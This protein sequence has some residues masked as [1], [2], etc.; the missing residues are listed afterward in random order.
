MCQCNIALSLLSLSSQCFQFTQTLYIKCHQFIHQSLLFILSNVFTYLG[1][2]KC[3]HLSTYLS[4]EW[5][6]TSYCDCICVYSCVPEWSECSTLK[7]WIKWL[8]PPL[9]IH[10]MHIVANIFTHSFICHLLPSTFLL[11]KSLL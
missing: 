4:G 1:L 3:H 5:P 7:R 8:S 11:M 9:P 2:I 10:R 6:I